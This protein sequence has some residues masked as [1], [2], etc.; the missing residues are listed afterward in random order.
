MS[1]LKNWALQVDSSVAKTLKKLPQRDVLSIVEVIHLLPQDPFFGDIQ[2]M[3][4]EGN[5]WRRRV[6]SYRIFYKLYFDQKVVLIFRVE[7]RTSN[8][9]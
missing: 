5:V 6:G 3:K 7:R 8:T 4:G 2:K 9:Y 1:S